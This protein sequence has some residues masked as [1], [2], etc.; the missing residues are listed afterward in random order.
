MWRP[1][2][3]H[4]PEARPPDRGAELVADSLKDVKPLTTEELRELIRDVM[5]QH[6]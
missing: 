6:P 1:T 2:I 5:R 4:R 3:V